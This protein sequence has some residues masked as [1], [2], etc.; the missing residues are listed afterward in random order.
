MDMEKIFGSLR[1]EKN[2]CFLKSLKTLSEYK[3][4]A[5]KSNS[6]EAYEALNFLYSNKDEKILHRLATI[7]NACL[8]QNTQTF[9]LS[10]RSLQILF[11]KDTDSQYKNLSSY[12]YR[13]LLVN[14][15]NCDLFEKLR[16]PT[17]KRA[18]VY[19]LV[20]PELVAILQKQVGK[21]YLELKEKKVLEF[22]ESGNHKDELSDTDLVLKL[23]KAEKNIRKKLNGER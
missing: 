7:I 17:G 14:I 18:G 9:C 2:D 15:T 16:E 10:Y 5:E 3:K 22:Y 6:P 1:A 11:T 13:L 23:D 20:E 21:K 8:T 12:D 19:R 4:E